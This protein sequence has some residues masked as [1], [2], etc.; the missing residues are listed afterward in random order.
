MGNTNL[1]GTLRLYVAK[2]ARGWAVQRREGHKLKTIKSELVSAN[3][4]QSICPPSALAIKLNIREIKIGE[5]L[6]WF[7]GI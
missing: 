7:R 4:L 2:R 3:V 1:R 5:K 6:K